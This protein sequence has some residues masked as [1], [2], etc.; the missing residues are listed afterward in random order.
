V[1]YYVS[2]SE[3]GEEESLTGDNVNGR[4]VIFLAHVAI[5]DGELY[6]LEVWCNV[7]EPTS[8]IFARS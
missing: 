4:G 2:T 8:G 1:L 7:E 5:N 3:V 6:P